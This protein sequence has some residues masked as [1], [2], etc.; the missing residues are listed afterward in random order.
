M[1]TKLTPEKDKPETIYTHTVIQIV[2]GSKR[3]KE[4]V[5]SNSVA[6]CWKNY[7]H[8]EVR[9]AGALLKKDVPLSIIHSG[10]GCGCFLPGRKEDVGQGP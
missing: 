7:S 1:G 2:F 6:L 3:Q 5:S 9:A 8:T 4:Q 10:G